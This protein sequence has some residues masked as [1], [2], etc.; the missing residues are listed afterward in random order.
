MLH[1][2]FQVG[3]K[4]GCYHHQGGAGNYHQYPLIEM[5]LHQ[6]PPTEMHLHQFLVGVICHHD[7]RKKSLCH[8]LQEEMKLYLLFQTEVFQAEERQLFHL[9]R[10]D[11]THFNN[12]FPLSPVQNCQLYKEFHTLSLR[13]LLVHHLYL[14]GVVGKTTQLLQLLQSL[15][16]TQ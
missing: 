15:D 3:Q 6:F 9:S 11:T 4:E 14:V 7:L 1:L 8:L 12:Q 10:P 13:K 16:M 2:H 5:Y